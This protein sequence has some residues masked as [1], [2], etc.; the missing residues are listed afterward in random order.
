M[1][2]IQNIVDQLKT[3]V[4]PTVAV[5]TKT[6][7]FRYI[8]CILIGILLTSGYTYYTGK[9]AL[10]KELRKIDSLTIEI[11]HLNEEYTKMQ[12]IADSLDNEI[13]NA[14][15]QVNSR[16]FVIYKRPPISNSDSASVFLSKFIHE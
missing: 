2:N 9:L 10:E 12:T 7:A 8:V 11:N 15:N 5:F 13:L 4:V 14:K 3:T 6:P 16:P 1:S